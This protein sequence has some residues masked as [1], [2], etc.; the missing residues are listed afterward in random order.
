MIIIPISLSKKYILILLATVMFSSCADKLDITPPNNITDEQIQQL[1]ASGNAE[2]IKLVMGSMA[3][4]MPL[5]FNVAGIAGPYLPVKIICIT[6][7]VGTAI[8]RQVC[9]GRIYM[10]KN[11]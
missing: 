4:N 6:T 9:Y 7:N 3:N 5:L 1:L 11:R 8:L 2:T 10:K